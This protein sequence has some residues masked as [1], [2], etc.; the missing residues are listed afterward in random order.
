MRTVIEAELAF[1]AVGGRMALDFVATLGKRDTARIERLRTPGD[2][3]RWARHAGVAAAVVDA[4]EAALEP[5]RRLREALHR[6]VLVRLGRG[7]ARA[8]DVNLVNACAMAD[9]PPSTLAAHGGAF[10]R[11]LPRTT[12]AGLLAAVAR[13]AVDLLTG[14][15]A[16]AVREC[17]GEA[18]TL[19]FVDASR[20]RR[21]RW[22]S[23]DLCGARSKMRALR[24]RQHP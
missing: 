21:R 9:A 16:T 1:P 5:A 3:E 18:C 23:M 20:G 19:L 17:E 6:L 14:P 12:V 10:R 13:D 8:D 4:D 2:L 24:A 7:H 22:C 11:E 15:D